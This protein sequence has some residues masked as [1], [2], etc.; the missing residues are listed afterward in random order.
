MFVYKVQ[1]VYVISCIMLYQPAVLYI[2]CSL[3][4]GKRKYKLVH[5]LGWAATTTYF[6]TV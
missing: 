4:T 1:D 3:I 2:T 5:W 6:Y